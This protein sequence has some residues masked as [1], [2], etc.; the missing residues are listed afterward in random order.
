MSDDESIR[1]G[2]TFICRCI[3]VQVAVHPYV[4]QALHTF[5]RLCHLAVVHRVHS[6]SKGWG[7][8]CARGP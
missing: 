5:S 1:H 8:W 6:G 2:P 3:D 7:G 4:F